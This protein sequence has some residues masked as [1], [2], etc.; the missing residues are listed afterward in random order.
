MKQIK[1]ILLSISGVGVLMAMFWVAVIMLNQEQITETPLSTL[2]PTATPEINM[3]AVEIPPNTPLPSLTPTQTLL[4]PPTLEPPTPLPQPTNTPDATATPIIPL[5][6]IIPPLHGLETATPT[7]QVACVPR[8]D[9]TLTY[10]V[11]HDDALVKIADKYQTSVDALVQ[12]NCLEDANVIYLGQ[13]LRVPGGSHPVAPAYVCQDW[14]V[15][16]PIDYGV[17]ID[18]NGQ[19]TFN[20]RGSNGERSLIRVY[21]EQG[22]VFWERVI[23]LRQ[24]ETITLAQEGFVAGSYTWQVYPLNL[25]YQ[26]IP[27]VESPRW[28]FGLQGEVAT[29]P[30]MP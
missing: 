11:T 9:W 16:T 18:V 5:S 10:E 29:V 13:Q 19:I 17:L 15:L 24:N 3:D 26:Q 14:Q 7:N 8:K 6:G 25:H 1:M 28:N 21:N 22:H 12:A 23:D 27:C 2:E 20:W 30:S 4:P